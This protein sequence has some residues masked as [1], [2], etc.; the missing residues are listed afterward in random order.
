MGFLLD[1]A[2]GKRSS[3][4]T[5]ALREET[6]KRLFPKIG[7]D[8]V[9]RE[10]FFIVIDQLLDLVDPTRTASIDFRRDVSARRLAKEYKEQLNSGSGKTTFRRDLIK[11]DD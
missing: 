4:D 6:Y 7:R 2:R 8:F 5:Q 9:S 1:S 3:V 10:D 11:L